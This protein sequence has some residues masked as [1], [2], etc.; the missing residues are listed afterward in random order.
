VALPGTSAISDG[1]V[2]VL[3]DVKLVTL[4]AIIAAIAEGLVDGDAAI[5]STVEVTF[6]ASE[7]AETS[8]RDALVGGVAEIVELLVEVGAVASNDAGRVV[9]PGNGALTVR[10]LPRHQ[11]M[12]ELS[13][14]TK[15]NVNGAVVTARFTTVARIMI[16]VE[17]SFDALIE[18][19]SGPAVLVGEVVDG[20]P[21]REV[22]RDLIE[23]IVGRVT[24]LFVD[25][26]VVTPIAVEVDPSEIVDVSGPITTI[27]SRADLVRT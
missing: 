12:A 11:R 27:A 10:V 6:I 14:G 1:G 20:V 5:T 7:V 21:E 17:E 8:S 16:A 23:E 26:V 15:L 9:L 24:T 4:N 3:E 13:G 19:M 25:D 2:S 22:T 18:A